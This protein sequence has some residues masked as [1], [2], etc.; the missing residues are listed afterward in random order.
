MNK[1]TVFALVTIAFL[2]LSCQ[3]KPQT[4]PSRLD[5]PVQDNKYDSEFPTK[6]TS[7]YL[8][9]IIE[10]VKMVSTLT[11][12]KAYDFALKDSVTAQDIRNDIY[13]TK[14]LNEYIYEQP[15][16]GTI[17]ALYQS[18]RKILFLTCSHIVSHKDSVFTYYA[19][20]PDAQKPSPY[21]YSFAKKIRQI[22]NLISI[23]GSSQPKILASDEKND[24]ALVGVTL[25]RTPRHPFPIFPYPLGKAQELEWG[26]F[27][28]LIGYP[29]G[30]LLIANSIVSAPN[31]DSNHSFLINATLTRG[32]SGGLIL[33]LRD[34]PPHFELVGIVS[35]LS[36]HLQYYLKPELLE[37]NTFIDTQNP[38]TGRAYIGKR[39]AGDSNIIFAIS[40]EVIT[41]FIRQNIPKLREYG[42]HI[43]AEFPR[44]THQ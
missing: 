33:A 1:K 41:R 14:A 30:K 9:R 6:P 20:S 31:R 23:P 36:A 10:S 7:A 19:A 43:P 35:A 40:A 44:V 8:S 21:L 11:F 24:L 16:A 29:K 3:P 18:D 39:L 15:S 32:V 17:V 27:V 26:S 42:F 37:H 22:T 28:Y 2:I 5:W 13:R 38:Y 12:Y 34:G 4:P 25:L